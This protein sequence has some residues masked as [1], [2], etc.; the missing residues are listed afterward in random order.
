MKACRNAAT[1]QAFRTSV[2]TTLAV[3][4]LASA[5]AKAQQTRSRPADSRSSANSIPARV[6]REV[7]ELRGFSTSGPAVAELRT[8]YQ[9]RRCGQLMSGVELDAHQYR[10]S[11]AAH[12]AW[13]EK[14]R[15]YLRESNLPHRICFDPGSFE[16]TTSVRTVIRLNNDYVLSTPRN[17]HKRYCIVGHIEPVESR[18][19]NLAKHRADEVERVSPRGEFVDR[20]FDAVPEP[21]VQTGSKARKVLLFERPQRLSCLEEAR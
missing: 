16:L 21:R 4:V 17:R 20:R 15:E 8:T 3:S 10:Y 18:I 6:D 7:E 9:P 1:K 5:E 2:F 13:E 14:Q 12:A 11:K 19:Q